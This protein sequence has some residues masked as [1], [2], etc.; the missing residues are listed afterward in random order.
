MAVLSFPAFLLCFF[1]LMPTIRR[2]TF[3]VSDRRCGEL[4]LVR[5]AEGPARPRRSE[6]DPTH[7]VAGFVSLRL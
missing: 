4:G 1:L 5:Q 7:P 2:L 3:L 6:D